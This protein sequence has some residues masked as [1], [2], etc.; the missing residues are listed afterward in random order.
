MRP[1]LSPFRYYNFRL[2]SAANV[3]SVIG[4]WMQVLAANWLILSATGSAAHMGVGVLLYGIPVLLLGP[5]GGALADRLPARPL[6][7]IT[8]LLHAL[9]ALLLA[10]TAYAGPDTLLPLVYGALLLGG[11]VSAMDGPALGR[12]GS[13]M[14]DR[15]TLAAAL[16]VGSLANSGGRIVGM[17]LGGL[18]IAATGPGTLFL[19]NA[20]SFLVVVAVLWMLRP[21]APGATEARDPVEVPDVAHTPGSAGIPTTAWAGVR[22]VLRDPRIV[23]TLTLAFLLGS[24]GR[25]YQVTMAAMSAGPLGGGPEG[26]GLLS[27]IFAAGAIVGGLFAAHAGRAGIPVLMAVGVSISALQFLSGLAPD[28]RIF[29]A[30]M[31]PIAA[32]AVLID[33]VVATR[34]QLDTPLAVRGRVLAILGAVSAVAGSVGAPML[35]WLSDA[36]GPRAALELAGAV[37]ALGCAVAGVGWIVA[38]RRPAPAEA[39]ATAATGQ[40]ELMPAAA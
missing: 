7:T 26:Y 9:V 4:T 36:L 1:I 35:G 2:W 34:L 6:L 31:L 18:L 10:V 11:V 22:Y 33:T 38:R 17:S 8:Q 14:V 30:L 28:I 3:I 27:T 20:G 12:F 21:V 23:I 29:G 16:A 24:L 13:I 5:W 40:R 32:G 37:T 19:L 39:P 15:S 25:N